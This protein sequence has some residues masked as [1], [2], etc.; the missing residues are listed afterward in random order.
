MQQNPAPASKAERAT[1]RCLPLQLPSSYV[2]ALT[3]RTLLH[4]AC[5][6]LHKYLLLHAHLCMHIV[7]DAGVLLIIGKSVCA[8][9]CFVTDHHIV[10]CHSSA[11]CTMMVPLSD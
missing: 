1:L 9:A 7:H 2:H 4:A 8:L 11:L 6:A 10:C 5:S 3:V